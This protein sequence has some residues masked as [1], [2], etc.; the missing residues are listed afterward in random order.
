MMTSDAT[1]V[2]D[3]VVDHGLLPWETAEALGEVTPRLMG[4]LNVNADSFSD[5]RVVVDGADD[6]ARLVAAGIGLSE[7]GADI[8]DVG[9]ESASPATLAVDASAEIDALLPVL[10]GLHG[11]GVTTSVDTYKPAV[12]RACVAAGTAVIN[13]YSG[14]VHSE[15]AGICAD[16]GARLVL[17]HNPAGVKNKVLDPS[18]YPNVIGDVMAWFEA[19]IAMVEDQGLAADRVLL[20]PGIDLAKT[21]AQSIALLRGLP[22]LA[23]FGLPLLVAISRKDFIGAVSPSNP[24]ER[25]PGTLAALG[26]LVGMPQVIARVH[27]V[28]AAAQYIRVADTLAGRAFVDPTLSL[29]P[30]LRREAAQPAATPASSASP[31]S[32]SRR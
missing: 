32:S 7:A 17:T 16:G 31:R 3:E 24:T 13:D 1:P 4:I 29:A 30:Q 9:A 5:P 28:A 6:V 11:A 19:K 15:V 20:D 26:H 2:R 23:G 8:V 25:D 14:L 12:A 22:T 18:G 27:D 21:P 10:D